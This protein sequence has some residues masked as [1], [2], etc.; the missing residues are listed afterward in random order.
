MGCQVT[1]SQGR[2]PGRSNRQALEEEEVGPGLLD[3]RSGGAEVCRRAHVMIPSHFHVP[4][5]VELLERTV[6][7]RSSAQGLDQARIE[8]RFTVGVG[9]L[10]HF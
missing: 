8:L 1:R 9:G 4:Y 10:F 6:S 3:T 7:F 5:F 2:L